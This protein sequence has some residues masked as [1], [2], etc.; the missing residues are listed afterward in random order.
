MITRVAPKG[1]SQFNLPDNQ[2][3]KS[4]SPSL[5]HEWCTA[6]EN[7]IHGSGGR[8]VLIWVLP[9]TQRHLIKQRL[10]LGAIMK[11]IF[12]SMSSSHMPSRAD[13]FASGNSVKNRATANLSSS[14][15][16]WTPRHTR[17]VS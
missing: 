17:A 2:F 6:V 5:S 12:G 11:K 15:A 8:S 10:L 16:K 13:T 1:G 9:H 14:L 3:F 7:S 4:L